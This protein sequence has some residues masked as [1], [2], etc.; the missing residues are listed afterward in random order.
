MQ[1]LNKLKFE[2]KIDCTPY[3]AEDT[4]VDMSMA[5]T[6]FC[7]FVYIISDVN[8]FEMQNSFAPYGTSFVNT[9]QQHSEHFTAIS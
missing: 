6:K 4:V 8:D 5:L 3:I 1:K 9:Q 2:M 7:S